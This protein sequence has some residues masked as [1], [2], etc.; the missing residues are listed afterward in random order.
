MVFSQTGIN[1]PNPTSTLDITA[2]NATGTSTTVDGLLIPRV[3][4]QRAQSMTSI[5]TSTLIYVNN[6]ATG[7]QTGIAANINTIGYYSFD[8]SAWVKINTGSDVNIYNSN[9]T[10]TGARVVTTGGNP[11]FFTNGSNNVNMGTNGNMSIV[12]AVG[13]SRG[14]FKATGGAANL[15]L[16]VDDNFPAQVASDGTSTQLSIGT[17]TGTPVNIKTNT[18]DRVTVTSAG[19]VGIG[20]A[21][22]NRV[23][24]VSANSNPI[25]MT[26]LPTASISASLQPLGI[27]ANG[28]IYKSASTTFGAAS[29]IVDASGGS[30]LVFGAGQ[31]ADQSTNI[32]ILNENTDTQNAYNPATGLFTVPADGWY[33][34][35]ARIRLEATGGTFD[36]AMGTLV[37]GI[38]INGAGA[39][40][41]STIPVFRG[42]NGAFNFSDSNNHITVWLKQGQTVFPFFNTTSTSNMSNNNNNIKIRRLFSAFQVY[43][44]Q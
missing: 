25:R 22:P 6:I 41:S 17:L 1:T 36:G 14:A 26:N 32:L 18:I 16:F 23:L 35:F 40:T 5:P 43:K 19:N 4:R 28:D 9:G 31:F 7:T 11:L 27:D 15:N 39:F 42:A 38:I 20:T 10:L 21:T 44:L 37:G 3:D 24:E 29:L 33:L 8:G 13:S 12:G 2:K 34:L 30:D